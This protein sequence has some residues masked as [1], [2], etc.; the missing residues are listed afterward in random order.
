MAGTPAD[1][2]SEHRRVM[3]IETDT[4]KGAHGAK[5]IKRGP[6][7]GSG[8][9]NYGKGSKKLTKDTGDGTSQI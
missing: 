9:K 3:E 1:R 2:G 5:I 6:A 8:L 7:Y 4:Q